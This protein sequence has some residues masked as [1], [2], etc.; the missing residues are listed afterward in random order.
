MWVKIEQLKLDAV[1]APVPPEKLLPGLLQ[2]TL[3]M[4][5]KSFQILGK[6]VDSRRGRPQILYRIAAEVENLPPGM[7]ADSPP[8]D[9][10]ESDL[11]RA[12]E[13][14]LRNPIVVG[15]GPCG[16]FAALG[17]ALAGCDPVILERG[18]EV[19]QRARDIQNFLHTRDLDPESNLL[20][21][22]GGAGTFSDGKLY[23]NSRDRRIAFILDTFVRCGAPE[24]I[25]YLK[26]PHIGS[27]H[28]GLIAEKLRRKI[29]SLG[30]T[31]RFGAGVRELIVREG[32]C[33][34]VKLFSGEALEGP[35]TV[36][37][38]GLGGRDLTLALCRQGVPFVMKNFQLGCRIEHP[39]EWVDRHQYRMMTRPAALQAAEYHLSVSPGCGALGVS[40]FC[41]CPGGEVLA[42]SAWPGQ[43]VS[44]GM[45]NFA[46]SG[47][48]AD[49]ALIATLSG[50]DF[51]MPEAAY[52]FLRER[53]EAAF[54]MGGS[55]YTFPAQSAAAFLRG[56]T[57]LVRKHASVAT[58]IC[59]GR[60]DELLPKVISKALRHALP[61]LDRKCPGFIREGMFL[62]LESCI[63]SP[64]RF[65]R[66]PETG[67]SPVKG[68][69]CGGEFGG[70]AG[71]ITS[72]AADGLKIAWNLCAPRKNE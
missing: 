71:G 32:V 18:Q 72:A 60:I 5:F 41:M 10:D 55:N 58:G 69:Y 25:R 11:W 70:W 45:S 2:K 59:P 6:S 29:E 8:E 57:G 47:E 24:E 9:P 14:D 3:G 44:N 17:L 49:A 33:R 1:S 65:L 21:G 13:P 7:T 50:A 61:E 36:L 46:R 64:V 12:L 39:Q 4:P 56:E 48:F 23:T 51:Q 66:D 15:T 27:D 37:A 22:E 35:C 30:G 42:A 63:S 20:I 38:A 52:Q 53:E 68:L 28:L 43:L 67:G 40:S 31:F 62:G 19:D 26:R 34:G 54:R 16:I